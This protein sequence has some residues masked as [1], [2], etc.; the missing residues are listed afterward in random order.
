MEGVEHTKSKLIANN[1]VE[2]YKEDGT[3]VIRLH[4]TDILEFHP[5]GTLMFNSGGWKTPTTKD[6]MNKH[7]SSAT[8]IQ[9]KG[10]WYLSTSSNPWND[11]DSW[12]SF[13][14]GIKIRNGKVLNPK[15]SAHQKEQVLLKQIQ[16]YC[17]KLKDLH[18]L[19]TPSNGDCWYCAF[20]TDDGTPMGDTKDN[21]PHLRSHLK[22]KYIH[23]SL[24]INALQWGGYPNPI[25]I[26]NMGFSK[27][28]PMRDTIVRTVRRYFKAKLGL[29]N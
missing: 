14:D 24:I 9:N 23:G 5:D 15:K 19:P 28:G 1:T 3:K 11:K 22:E 16:K 6:R 27:D 13:F 4:Q 20:H 26:F 17:E 18:V 21:V 10:L 8:I 12:V 2:Y 29:A 25:L 7:Q